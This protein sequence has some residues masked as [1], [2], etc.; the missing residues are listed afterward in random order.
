M[1]DTADTEKK[2]LSFSNITERKYYHSGWGEISGEEI[3]S[4]TT[5][6]N[7]CCALHISVNFAE[8]SD[9]IIRVLR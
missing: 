6:N 1:S 3:E 7:F 4:I 2:I 8:V 9:V 5:M